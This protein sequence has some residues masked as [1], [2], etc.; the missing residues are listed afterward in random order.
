MQYIGRKEAVDKI[1]HAGAGIF[2]VTFWKKPRLAT[3]ADL[4]ASG[5]AEGQELPKM[6]M[7]T[8]K[9]GELRQM[10][11]MK[12]AVTSRNVNEDILVV[13]ESRKLNCREGV[14]TWHDKVTGEVETLKGV[15]HA[16]EPAQYYLC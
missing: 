4:V 2:S 12:I 14:K 1:Y 8:N 10:V 5:Y 7:G 15:G 6:F 16:F 13:R 9:Y 3:E 11:L